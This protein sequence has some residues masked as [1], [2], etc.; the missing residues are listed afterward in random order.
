MSWL[1]EQQRKHAEKMW[2]EFQ[3]VEVGDLVQLGTWFGDVWAEIISVYKSESMGT[4]FASVTFVIYSKYGDE[5]YTDSTYLHNI[6]KFSKKQDQMKMRGQ[7]LH[8]VDR[9]VRFEGTVQWPND[10]PRGYSNRPE[11]HPDARKLNPRTRAP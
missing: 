10:N 3:A 7:R 9:L 5:R 6:R 1:E 4:R 2:P 8:L 11:Y